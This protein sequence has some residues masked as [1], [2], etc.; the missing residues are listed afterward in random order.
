MHLESKTV[1]LWPGSDE[2]AEATT[3]GDADVEG[4]RE[5]QRS[6]SEK[7]DSEQE[8]EADASAK[9]GSDEGLFYFTIFQKYYKHS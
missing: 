3:Q 9:E 2:E 8:E 4:D 6:G 1:P 7:A 5:E